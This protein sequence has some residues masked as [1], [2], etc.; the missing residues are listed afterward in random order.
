[1]KTRLLWLIILLGSSFMFLSAQT[2]YEVTANTFLNIRSAASVDAP[3]VGIINRGGEVDVYSIE[4]GW[5]KIAYDGGYAY[6]SSDYLKRKVSA[7]V[8]VEKSV[9]NWFQDFDL[10]R[11]SKGW[12]ARVLVYV[13]AGLSVLLWLIRLM[14]GDDVL[15]GVWHVINCVLFSLMMCLELVYSISMGGEATW[16]CNPE[17][18]GW[19]WMV[20]NFIIFGFLIYNQLICFVNTLEDMA[21]DSGGGFELKWGFNSLR[22]GVPIGVVGAI[23]SPGIA[24][25]VL[26]VVLCC[27]LVQVIKIFWGVVPRGGWW[28]STAISLV[29]LLGIFG[30]AILLIHFL[31]MLVV[32]IVALF[33]L[34]LFAKSGSNGRRCC[35]NCSHYSY[36]YCKLHGQSISDA[37]GTVCDHYN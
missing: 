36:G 2:R 14:R 24:S 33:L 7:S 28:Y 27:Q 37:S 35:S 31:V 8:D 18:V 19:L 6:V 4:N 5:A 3:V 23:I 11:W 16:F 34:K 1:M 17:K 21:C 29:Y 13:V 12:D 15:D 20:V 32:V 26:I 9:S 30:T 10:A 25:I 22:W